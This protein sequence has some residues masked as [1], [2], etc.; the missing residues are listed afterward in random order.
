MYKTIL[1]AIAVQTLSPAFADTFYEKTKALFE[2]GTKPQLSDLVGLNIGRCFQRNNPNAAYA[3]AIFVGPDHADVGPIGSDVFLGKTLRN[4][5]RNYYENSYLDVLVRE[6]ASDML[7]IREDNQNFL[8]D[9]NVRAY[10]N[11]RRVADKVFTYEVRKNSDY[12]V[13]RLGNFEYC[14]TFYKLE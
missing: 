2:G 14:Y 12:L 4:K 5:D 1:I 8:I 13:Y 7:P 10:V 11:D 3:G 9:Q 6:E